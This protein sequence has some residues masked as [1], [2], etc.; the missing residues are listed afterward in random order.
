MLHRE[1]RAAQPVVTLVLINTDPPR[2]G[3][4]RPSAIQQ[5]KEPFSLLI[6]VLPTSHRPH[7]PLGIATI[8]GI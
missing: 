7:H 8:A 1:P 5:S 4:H 2:R 6:R 3:P